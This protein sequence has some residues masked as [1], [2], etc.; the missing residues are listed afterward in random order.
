[1]FAFGQLLFYF[2][3][4]G[5]HRDGVKK[6]KWEI[7]SPEFTACDRGHTALGLSAED[8]AGPKSRHQRASRCCPPGSKAVV[9]G[10]RSLD[11]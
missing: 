4:F 9:H 7:P 10:P 1:M 5:I 8:S 3:F 6:S 2:Y 11:L